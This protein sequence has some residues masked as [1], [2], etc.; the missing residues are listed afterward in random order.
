MV[1]SETLVHQDMA[2]KVKAL[3]SE[4]VHQFWPIRWTNFELGK[5]KSK[6]ARTPEISHFQPL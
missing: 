4:K 6:K 1:F 2:D 3:T 5:G